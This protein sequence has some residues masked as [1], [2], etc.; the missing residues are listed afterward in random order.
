MPWDC[1]RPIHSLHGLFLPFLLSSILPRFRPVPPKTALLPCIITL[2][3]LF[4]DLLSITY[5][6]FPV[7]NHIPYK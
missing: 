1:I 6:L 7:H 3:N 5:G 4:A 2:T